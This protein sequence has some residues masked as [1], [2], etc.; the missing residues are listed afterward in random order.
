MKIVAGL[1]AQI[2]DEVRRA[3]HLPVRARGVGEA[4]RKR[5]AE[6]QRRFADLLNRLSVCAAERYLR[7]E[8]LLCTKPE[9]QHVGRRARERLA[10]DNA[11]CIWSVTT[12]RRDAIDL[13][14]M[15]GV[16]EIETP[17]IAGILVDRVDTVEFDG[18]FAEVLKVADRR[19]VGRALDRARRTGKVPVTR[20]E[21]I[22]VELHRL[23]Q[24]PA[25]QHRAHPPVSDGQP[26]RLPCV[27]TFR[28]LA[29]RKYHLAGV[30]RRCQAE[31]CRH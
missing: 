26:L 18:K 9:R 8:R 17:H 10:I 30:S 19:V 7:R 16:R 22:Y 14:H 5:S 13:H 29:M 24:K 15:Q 3:I 21:R 27:L 1:R 25:R 20:P 4:V 12:L 28:S 31:S 6:G 23:A 11:S 2:D